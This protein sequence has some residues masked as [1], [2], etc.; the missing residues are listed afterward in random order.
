MKVFWPISILY[1]ESLIGEISFSGE[2]K[3]S[4]SRT[5]SCFELQGDLRED[6]DES[7]LDFV[8]LTGV[9]IVFGLVFLLL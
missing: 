1:R 8:E 4:L 3:L 5:L 6:E 2:L 7:T 9:I